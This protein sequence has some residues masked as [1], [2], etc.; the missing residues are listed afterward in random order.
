MIPGVR[1]GHVTD[2][3]GLTG[4]TVVLPDRPAVGGVDVRGSATVAARTSIL[5]IVT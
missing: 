3:V 2:L 4:V 1:V 5:P